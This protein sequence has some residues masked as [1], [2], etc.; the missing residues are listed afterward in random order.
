MA[1]DKVGDIMYNCKES[2]W[3]LYRKLIGYWQEKY[4]EKRLEEYKK[5][6]NKQENPSSRFWLLDKVIEEDKNTAGVLIVN[7]SRSKLLYILLGLLDC[8]VITFDDLSDFSD[9]LKKEIN[10]VYSHK[11]K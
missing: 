8:E 6:L 5:I 4:I 1:G 2:D 9:E 3:K 10:F 7:S 11:N